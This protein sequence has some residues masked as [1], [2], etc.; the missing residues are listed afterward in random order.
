MSVLIPSVNLNITEDRIFEALN[1]V[2]GIPLPESDEPEHSLKKS[3]SLLATSRASVTRL[4]DQEILK[5]KIKKPTPKEFSTEIIQYT[6]LEVNFA[7][8]G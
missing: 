3:A 1:I 5:V 4:I 6:N 2:T 8:K 7:L